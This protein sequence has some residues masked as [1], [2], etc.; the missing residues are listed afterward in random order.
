MIRPAT[1]ED[2][3]ALLEVAM[4]SGL[5]EPEQVGEL[6]EML[7][8][9]FDADEASEI[10]LTDDEDGRPVGVAYAAPERMTDGTWNLYLVALHPDHQR[11]GRGK[12]ILEHVEKLLTDHGVRVMLV[13]TAGTDDFDYVRSFYAK[14]GYNEEARIGEFYEAG[15][16]KVVYRKAL[17]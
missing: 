6:A 4:A 8:N 7:G 11:K 17:R 3:N 13:E 10:W 1:P 15:V 16:D 9:H 5:F 14:S 2:K 12:A